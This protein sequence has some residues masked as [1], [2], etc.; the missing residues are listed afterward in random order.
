MVWCSL[1]IMRLGAMEN[2][3]VKCDRGRANRD[4]SSFD[5]GYWVERNF[6]DVED[7]SIADLAPFSRPILQELH[8]D[9]AL[10]TLH[11]QALEWRKQRFLELMKD[12][13]WRALFGRLLMT[14]P[15]RALTPE[16]AR[17]IWSHGPNQLS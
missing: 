3:L 13:P 11:A 4:A 2:Y 1:T 5:M 6:C 10:A 15:A 12:E 14:P 17:L 16:E 8:A 7:N 9:D